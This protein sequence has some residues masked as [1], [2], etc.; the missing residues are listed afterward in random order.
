[1][2][3]DRSEWQEGSRSI[4]HGPLPGE[5][6]GAWLCLPR[7]I[8]EAWAPRG[9]RITVERR[10][11][12][13]ARRMLR[14]LGAG[15]TG[16][17]VA[18]GGE[19]PGLLPDGVGDGW[20]EDTRESSASG[21]TRA[22]A[23]ALFAA[24][25]ARERRGD[26]VAA[27]RWYEGSL[28]L[29]PRH[30]QLASRVADAAV[31][32]GDWERAMEWW[33]RVLEATD[34]TADGLLAFGRFCE[35]HAARRD[36]LGDRGLAAIEQAVARFPGQART[37]AHLVAVR[38]GR[39]DREAAVAALERA[40]GRD[41]ADA[42]YW[43]GLAPS[44]MA[45]WPPG[46]GDH[47]E[48]VLRIFERARERAP[49]D[50]EV[51]E[52]MADFLALH[53]GMVEAARLYGEVVERQPDDL[54]AREKRARTLALSDRRDEAVAA[55]QDV[56]QIDPQH[57]SAHRALAR[58]FSLQGDLQASVRHRVEALR[59]GRGETVEEALRLVR[60]MLQAGL[61]GEALTVLERAEFMAPGIPDPPYLA[62]LAHLA[63]GDPVRAMAAFER[64]AAVAEADPAQAARFLD[65]GFFFDWGLA[66]SLAERLEV[67]EEKFRESIARVP[68]AS[69]ERAAK[70]YNGLAY[71]WIDRG[72]RLEEAAPLI[73]RALTLDPEN[74]AFLDTLGWLHFRKGEFAEALAVLEQAEAAANARV[75]EIS[76]HRAQA[77][78]AIGRTTEA[79]ALLEE[80][81]S[82][83]DATGA[84]GQ[85]LA[86][87]RAAR[88]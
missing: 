19:L 75:A 76:D 43:L 24:G 9:R 31:A 49:D 53:G 63:A 82:W 40:L 2:R 23:M 27:L 10:I 36:G 66:A 60:E 70:S 45:I 21:E 69:P 59:W 12:G 1:M 41:D 18:L 61:P 65:E 7:S 64:A 35:R 8:A 88:P 71:L 58:H 6:P 39:G 16:V 17:A 81:V 20:S 52:A 13:A 44:A 68:P 83:P 67:A 3:R 84:M 4:E 87:W 48:K 56:L 73:R 80:V 15:A 77:L 38:A 85:R 22:R 33:D 32:T 29:D 74:P 50:P 86:E 62:G 25:L 30:W 79:V 28:G 51:I 34:G 78:W 14:W 46:T 47:R 54:R 5:F 26:A 72:E 57:E 55:W 42:R 11:T 37:H